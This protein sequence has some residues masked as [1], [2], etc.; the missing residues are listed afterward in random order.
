M[1]GFG[2][3]REAEAEFILTKKGPVLILVDDPEERLH[4]PYARSQLADSLARE[5]ATH[6]AVQ[7]IVS[8]A[9]L[10]RL[11]QRHTDFEERGC[12]EVGEM[13][14]AEQVLWVQVRDFLAETDPTEV[15]GAARMSVT[16]KVINA[17][18]KENAEKVRLWPDEREGRI[19]STDLDARAVVQSKDNTAVANKL[20]EKLVVE[21]AKPFYTR[22]L[23]D[24]E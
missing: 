17:L 22:V 6:Q 1:M 14:N 5:L 18:E 3:E 23:G 2:P 24:F 4:S 12:R 13:A 10:Q 16:V 11:R 9:T 21:I 20:M 8:Q 7:E 19:V 15:T